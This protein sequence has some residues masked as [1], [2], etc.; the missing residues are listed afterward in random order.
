MRFK[1]L[2]LPTLQ[3]YVSRED[4]TY[5]YYFSFAFQPK[6]LPLHNKAPPKKYGTPVDITPLCRLSPTQS[7]TVNVIWNPEPSAVNH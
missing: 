7:N 2:G 1:S 6:P 4:I 5:K 3:G